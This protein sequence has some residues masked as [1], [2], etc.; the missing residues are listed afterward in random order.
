[1]Q[2]QSLNAYGPQANL[3]G[4]DLSPDQGAA[5]AAAQGAVDRPHD[6]DPARSL[7][8][9]PATEPETATQDAESSAPVSLTTYTRMAMSVSTGERG[10]GTI[11][12]IA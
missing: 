7:D 9:D 1:V 5:H 10:S 3:I 8:S 12:L 11:S 4:S 6:P 2:I